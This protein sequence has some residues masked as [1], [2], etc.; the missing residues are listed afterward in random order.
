MIAEFFFKNPR[1]LFLALVA[2]TV[3]GIDSFLAT[4]RLE[5]PVLGK[6]VGIVTAVFP[7]AEASQVESLITTPLE[8]ALSEISQINRVRAISRSGIAHLV[9]ELKDEVVEFD[10]VW[11][12]VQK[13]LDDSESELPESA[14]APNLEVVPLRAFAAIVAI[15]TKPPAKPDLAVLRR[16]ASRLRTDILSIAGTES[17]QVFGDPGEEVVVEVEP[18]TLAATGLSVAA[19]AGQL[20]ESLTLRPGGNVG[21]FD[22]DVLVGIEQVAALEDKI[23]PAKI[24][25]GRGDS[26]SLSQIARI[27]KQLVTPAHDL[28]LIDQRPA[29]VL[30]ILVD[31][32]QQIDHWA[33]QFEDTVTRLSDQFDKDVEF[34]VLFSQSTHVQNRMRRLAFNLGIGS[35]AVALVVLVLMGWRSMIVVALSLP[36]SALMVMTG[37]KLLSIPIHQMSVTG[38]I[39]ALGLLID[40]AIVMVDEVRARVVAGHSRIDAISEAVRHLRMPLFGSTLTTALAF[41][42]IATLPGPSGEF[43][44]TIAISVILAICSSFILA[45]TLI[46]AAN[47]LMQSNNSDQPT[48]HGLSLPWLQSVYESSLRFVVRLPV[49]GVLLGM[50]LP[51]AGFVLATD[52]PVQFFPPSDRNQIQ[53]EV[54]LPARDR[55]SRTSKAVEAIHDVVEEN[56]AVLKQHWFIGQSAPTFFYN[57]VPR[58]RETP[59]YAQAIVDVREGVSTVKVVRELQSAIS[60]QDFSSRVIVRQ[61]EQGP[62]FDAPIEI[63]VIGPDLDVL[64]ELGSQLRKI[65]SE[66]TKVIHT[67]SDLGDTSIQLALAFDAQ[68]MDKNGLNESQVMGQIYTTLEGASAGSFLDETGLDLP[69]MVRMA[70]DDESPLDLLNAIPF[71]SR[72]TNG[73]PNA[74]QPPGGLSGPT[75]FPGAGGAPS[76]S[77]PTLGNLAELKLKS[78]SGAIVHVDR[79]RINEVKAYIEAGVLPSVVLAEFKQRLADSDFQLPAGYDLQ[80][81]GETEQRNNAVGSLIANGVLLFALMLLSLVAS[82]RSFRCALIIAS[83]GGLSVGLGPLA[84]W[85][86]GYPFGFTAIVGTMGLVGVAINDSIVVLAAIRANQSL[87]PES[88]KGLTEVV[89]SCTRHILATTLTTIAGFVPLILGGGGLLAAAC[90]HDCRWS[91][92]SN[93]SGTL[94][95]SIDVFAADV[96]R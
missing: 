79:R 93:I 35:A 41:W 76:V 4:P 95:R 36:I 34:E 88:R 74:T 43:V 82:F 30:G 59:F 61:L 44:G 86:F 22:N 17:V 40:N 5:D 23:G 85:I 29:V 96:Q 69:V 10:S 73:P 94:R 81:G 87:P 78:G 47:A 58:K 16:M 11:A 66:T 32:D 6:R 64:D 25:Y 53:I 70:T 90:D 50:I 9:V 68:A 77:H 3:A 83:I 27:E 8:E 31:N 72:S 19:I 84:L 13:A 48:S 67:R 46:P 91:W 54:E 12:N 26:T 14:L 89:S 33:L 65:V 71:S 18:Q 75:G 63:R 20:S 56:G 15:K 45:M 2:I 21:Q 28:A 57:V 49:V 51:I 92:R 24:K 60:K 62:P 7:G 39:V 80:F 1:I 38:L 42:P 52:L 55:I 37:L